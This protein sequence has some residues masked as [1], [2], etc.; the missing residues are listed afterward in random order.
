MAR[1]EEAGSL[2]H[3]ASKTVPKGVEIKEKEKKIHQSSG[4]LCTSSLWEREAHTYESIIYPEIEATC[5][6]GWT[7]PKK[8][9]LCTKGKAP[10]SPS[11]PVQR[12]TTPS[13]PHVPSLWGCQGIHQGSSQTNRTKVSG[14]TRP[15]VTQP[16][17]PC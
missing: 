11:A 14:R 9:Q 15:R 12:P 5:V 3:M 7:N 8:S 10:E 4:I 16:P 13:K 17:A 1:A 6:T 2:L